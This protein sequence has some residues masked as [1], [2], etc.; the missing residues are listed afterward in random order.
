MFTHLFSLSL[1][2]Y[3]GYISNPLVQWNCPQCLQLT[4]DTLNSPLPLDTVV[5]RVGSSRVKFWSRTARRITQAA[6][7]RQREEVHYGMLS[8]G[9]WL[10]AK[11]Y[12]PTCACAHTRTCAHSHTLSAE[13]IPIFPAAQPPPPLLTPP[14]PLPCFSLLLFESLCFC[15]VS[16]SAVGQ[17]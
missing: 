9:L 14:L 1:L 2:F 4:C 13:G 16:S 17:A 8:S 3:F 15:Y 5:P 10:A 7:R 11:P 6:E 12:T